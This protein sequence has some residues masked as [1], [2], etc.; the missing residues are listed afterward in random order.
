VKCKEIEKTLQE[1]NFD[2]LHATAYEGTPL[3]R[4]ILGLSEN[5]K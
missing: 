2:H 1:V 3:G 4:M 5:I